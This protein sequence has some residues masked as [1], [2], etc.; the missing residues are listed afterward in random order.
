[1]QKKPQAISVSVPITR[2]RQHSR[3][4]L[5]SQLKSAVREVEVDVVD[6][7]P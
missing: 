7:Q 2:F 6:I 1:V 5:V 3:G 4:P